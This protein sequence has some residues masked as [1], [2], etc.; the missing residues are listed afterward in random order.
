MTRPPAIAYANDASAALDDRPSGYGF[1]L[2]L[3]IAS[4][5]GASL[6][7]AA[8]AVL[9]EVTTG[10]GRVIPSQQM[11]VVQ[12]LEGG[13]VRDLAVREGDLVDKDQILMRIDDTSFASKLGE[14]RER[15][16]ALK[17]EITRLDAE[18]AGKSELSFDDAL[19]AAAPSSVR[20][21]RETFNARTQKLSSEISLLRQQIVQR[22]QERDEVSARQRK[23]EA[24]LKPLR[25]ELALNQQLAN[26]GNVAKVDVL[27]LQRQVAELDGDSKILASTLPR[28]VAAI[29]EANR[30]IEGAAQT[31]RTQAS[32]R[33][34]SVKSDLAVVEETIKGAQDR[35]TRA[36]V[37]SPV[38]GTINKLAITTLGAVVQPGQPLAEIVPVDDALRIE[39]RVRPKDIAFIRPGQNASVKV[40]AY[41]Y[42]IY[43]ALKGHVD[44]I[45]PDTIKDER[46]E[47][48]YQVIVRTD[49]THLGTA[50]KKL[51]IIP[52][53]QVS[54]DIQTG[55][56]TVMNYLLK[57]VLRAQKEAMRE[58]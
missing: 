48:Y 27:R 42:V 9:D 51:Q 53:L 2:L 46:G 32:E 13:I 28:A 20:A 18:A 8:Y 22:E 1:M 21:E 39:A 12:S 36:V 45:S 4:L 16:F 23:I 10:V 40:S 49:S 24:E 25:S 35:V 29:A 57:P 43:G 47:P 54:V 37:R 58:R 17:A 19:I 15:Q 50:D 31:F 38:R 44:R 14:I 26:A 33:L 56:R 11:Q 5:L 55:A 3:V 30:R 41:D 7:W 6:A 52:G 34:S